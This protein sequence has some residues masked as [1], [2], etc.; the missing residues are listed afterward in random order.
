[1]YGYRLDV[2]PRHSLAEQ[3]RLKAPLRTETR[4]KYRLRGRRRRASSPFVMRAR[5]R[6]ARRLHLYGHFFNA[7]N[8][9]CDLHGSI[10]FGP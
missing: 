8:S 10:D 5:L 3:A 6:S 9:E 4:N 2:R 1:M 7:R